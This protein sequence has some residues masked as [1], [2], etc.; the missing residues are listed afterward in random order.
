MAGEAEVPTSLDIPSSSR[1][2]PARVPTVLPIFRWTE[3]TAGSKRLRERQG[4]GI[5]VYVERPWFSSG[6]GELV[7]VVLRPS[8]FPLMG[9]EADTLRKYTS[10]WGMDPLWHSAETAP[11]TATDF[12]NVVASD[13]GLRL[14]ELDAPSVG[15]VGFEAK[16]DTAQDLWFADIEMVANDAYFPFVRLALARFQP[17]SIPGVHLSSIH[18]ADFVQVSPRRLATYDLSIVAPGKSVGVTLEGPGHD[19]GDWAR[20]GQT[21]VIARL[22]KREYGDTQV[23]EPL[24]WIPIDT[25]PLRRS[26]S[27][28]DVRWEGSLDLPD[29]LITPLR[30]AI[31]E[32]Q[33]LRADG[34]R[35][36]EFMRLLGTERGQPEAVFGA[37][38]IAVTADRGE[39][40]GARIVFADTTVVVT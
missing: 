7:G 8:G 1:P 5:R 6:A 13:T 16:F 18:L 40:F 4:G 33:V 26:Q 32:A 30:V 15:A 3:A 9:K 36:A 29:P 39:T 38:H 28:H 25:Q 24:G 23:N 20:N 12:A 22:E 21:I 31:I 37:A 19:E 27:G 2:Q 34:G 10:E 17:R 35:V 11:V 14:V